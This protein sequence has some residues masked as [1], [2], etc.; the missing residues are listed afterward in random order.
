MRNGDGPIPVPSNDMIGLRSIPA[1]ALL[2]GLL[3]APAAGQYNRPSAEDVTKPEAD[4]AIQKARSLAGVAENVGDVLPRDL[5]FTDSD[6]DAVTLGD[7][8]DEGRPVVLQF[9]YYKCPALCGEVMN[10]MASAMKSLG[11]DYRIGRDFE[12]LT[13]SFDSREDARLGQGE[14]AGDRRRPDARRRRDRGRRRPRRLGLL[15]RRG[16]VDREGDRGGGG[17]G[18]P[19]SPRPRS[20]ATPAC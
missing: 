3:A 9:A 4:V 20:T 11:E 18:S 14:Q 2:L 16:P 13:V 1:A 6:G 5:T 12:V 19:G 10:G 8:L 17:S 15:G 7:V